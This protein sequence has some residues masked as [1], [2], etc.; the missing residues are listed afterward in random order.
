[1]KAKRTP[2]LMSIFH[3]ARLKQYDLALGLGNCHSLLE[4]HAKKWSHRM[5]S[6][7][8]FQVDHMVLD[9]DVVS[10]PLVLLSDLFLHRKSAG[11]FGRFLEA[12]RQVPGSMLM[13]LLMCVPCVVKLCRCDSSEVPGCHC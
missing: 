4:T 1:M 12:S 13:G 9:S 11:G 8:E 5:V 2:S 3:D 7:T 10:L 6:Y